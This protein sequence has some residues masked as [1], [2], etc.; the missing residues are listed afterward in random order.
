MPESLGRLW[1]FSFC[2]LSRACPHT[3][4]CANMIHVRLGGFRSFA[5]PNCLGW[6]I[7]FR[8]SFGARSA[9]ERSGC[10]T[11]YWICVTGCVSGLGRVRRLDGDAMTP[12]VLCALGRCE[13]CALVWAKHSQGDVR[14]YHLQV[15]RHRFRA[16]RRF[17][18]SKEEALAP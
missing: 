17:A 15:A 9:G 12:R 16:L 4:L 10:V 14:R 18:R 7:P 1:V 8:S 3:G 2:T 6:L 13:F 11:R 5:L